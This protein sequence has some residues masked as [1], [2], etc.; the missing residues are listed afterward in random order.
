MTL[1]A[2]WVAVDSRKPSAIYIVSD[3]KITWGNKGEYKY[4]RKVF[5][6]LT[7]PNIFGYCGDVLFPTIF[8]SQLVSLIDAGLIIKTE[9]TYRKKTA[10]IIKYLKET[11]STYP[12]RKGDNIMRDELE[13]IYGTRDKDSTFHCVDIKWSKHNNMWT[14]QSLPMERQSY[15]LRI[16]G[17]GKFEFKKKYEEYIQNKGMRTSR[18]MFQT[19]CDTLKNIKDKHCGGAPQLVGIYSKPNSPARNYGIIYKNHR[20]ALGLLVDACKNM[21]ADTIEWRNELFEICNPKSMNRREGA[22]AQPYP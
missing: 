17:S 1:L 21:N 16:T 11:L 6:S 20:Y 8:L 7:S 2:S 13:I 18:A 9:W 15:Q 19:F 14:F 22:Q 3:S 5:A 10:A 4:G 12:Y